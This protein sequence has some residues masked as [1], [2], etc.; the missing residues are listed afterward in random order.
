MKIFVKSVVL[1][2]LLNLP[3]QAELIKAKTMKDVQ[4]KVD[5]VLKSQAPS[6]VLLALDIDMTL[7]QPD[8][9]AVYYPALIKYKEDFKR[10][11]GQFTPEQRDLSPS[12]TT[13]LVPQKWVETETPQIVKNIMEKGVKTIA[14][15][16]SFSGQLNGF[17]DKLI[18]MRRDQIQ[19]MGLDFTNS[20]Q[21]YTNVATYYDFKKYGGYYP[22]Y[23]HG[24]LSANAE[25]QNSKGDVITTFLKHVGPEYEIKTSKAGYYPK[26]AIL[27]DDKTVNI[28]NV[29]AALKA[30]DPD[31]QFI[32]ITYEG[33]YTYAPQDITKEDFQKFW[34]N[35]ACEARLKSAHF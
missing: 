17:D 16:A 22:M 10:I 28:E 15:T 19:K 31:I 6:D 33:A 30:Y 14:F 1:S 8:H 27:V 24:I 25:G 21:E 13:Q 12:L 26:V 3:A 7:T 23:Y 11:L 9:P 34:E 4:Q 29:E 35:V 18:I 5:E 32:G 20:F 2:I